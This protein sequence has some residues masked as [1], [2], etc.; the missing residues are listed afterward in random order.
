MEI[1]DKVTVT[2]CLTS[3]QTAVNFPYS[4]DGFTITMTIGKI[5]HFVQRLV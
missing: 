2:A 5:W 1:P 3:R 4:A